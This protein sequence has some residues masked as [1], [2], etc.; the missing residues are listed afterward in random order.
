M[1]KEGQKITK[2]ARLATVTMTDTGKAPLPVF[3]S[4]PTRRRYMDTLIEDLIEKSKTLRP[5]QYIKVENVNA[6]MR[7]EFKKR[8]APVL[9]NAEL[10]YKT[11]GKASYELYIVG[12]YPVE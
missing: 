3:D 12:S 11:V 5:L 10:K 8:L 6:N 1:P 2:G 7:G 4:A 9:K